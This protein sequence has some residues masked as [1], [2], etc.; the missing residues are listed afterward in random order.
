[1]D[2]DPANAL[3][4]RITDADRD[5]R[6]AGADKLKAMLEFADLQEAQAEFEENGQ[7]RRLLVSAIADEMAMA[8]GVSVTRVQNM[9]HRGR[10]VRGRLPF[11]WL[12]FTEGRVD[13]Y[14]IQGV[15][16]LAGRL[17]L[18]ES[19][20]R[21]DAACAK[22]APSH[23]VTETI[24]WAQR[25]VDTLEPWTK[26][27]R[28]RDAHERRTVGV[29]YTDEGGAELWGGYSTHQGLHI[30]QALNAS[31]EA[32]SADDP[33]TRDQFLADELYHRITHDGQ[34]NL[35]NTEVVLTMPVTSAA[36]L[37]DGPA[38][39]IDG[40]TTLPADMIRELL[41]HCETVFHRA[42]TDPIGNILDVTR[43]GR[44][45]TGDLRKA[46]A[47][48]DG[49]CSGPRCTSPIR[50][51]D[52]IIPWPDGPTGGRNGQG[53]CKRTHQQK[54]FGV[55]AVEIV[56]GVP[57]WTTPLGR[58]YQANRVQHPPDATRADFSYPE[59]QLLAMIAEAA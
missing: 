20:R 26:A 33:R 4:D 53:L 8:L 37:T 32:K 1:M 43:L 59:H 22:Y 48:R 7:R 44:F 9:L 14:V 34:A 30:E 3:L 41:S 46:I 55:L 35:V 10:L 6:R 31:L 25:R 51:I 54:T 19:F 21:F 29:N 12:A 50:E 5:E 57:V 45:F 47:V 52:H 58:T 56:K 15:G 36:G 42:I 24:R 16:E 23:T 39:T 40:R 38:S 28:E 49:N 18:E 27:D 11:T 13:P 17:E 2:V